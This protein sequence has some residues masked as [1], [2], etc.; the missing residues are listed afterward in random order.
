MIPMTEKELPK[1]RT[2]RDE[3]MKTIFQEHAGKAIKLDNF[4]ENTQRPLKIMGEPKIYENEQYGTKSVYWP[5]TMKYKG[6]DLSTFNIRTSEGS[7][8]RWL[9]KKNAQDFEYI[10]KYALFSNGKAEGRKF[11]SV[12]VPLKNEPNSMS[13]PL[14]A[15]NE[16]DA[17]S[18]PQT[19]TQKPEEIDYAGFVKTYKEK[20][21]LYNDNL[22]KQGEDES[23]LLKPNLKD[24]IERAP[25]FFGV[26]NLTDEQEV[27]LTEAFN[28]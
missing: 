22:V 5:V 16:I 23:K 24:L 26:D 2:L 6:Q 12:S 10:E 17:N 13:S 21:Q 25:K 3:E 28:Q 19:T 15:M 14:D 4:P 27:K 9:E 11:Q 18:V 7:Y 20:I 1:I 8:N